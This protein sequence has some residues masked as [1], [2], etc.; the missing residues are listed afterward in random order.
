MELRSGDVKER[1]RLKGLVPDEYGPKPVEID[2]TEASDAAHENWKHVIERYSR[3][4][5]TNAEDKLIALAGIAEM[6]SSPIR[7]RYIVGMWEKYLASQLL[8]YVEPVFED[9]R[10]SYPSRRPKRYRAPSFSWAAVDTPQGIRCAETMREEDLQI[11]VEGIH[12][13]T[14]ADNQFGLVEKGCYVEL[15]CAMRKIEIG[16]LEKKGTINYVWKLWTEQEEGLKQDEGSKQEESSKQEQRTKYSSVYLDSPVDD[17]DDIEGRNGEIYC[18]PAGKD[19]ANYLMCLLLKKQSCGLLSV[20]CYRRVG[21]TTIPPY[22]GGQEMLWDKA[23]KSKM[24]RV[25]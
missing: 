4:A 10:F 18:V 11:S 2:P 20:E 8:W 25:I 14:K 23:G 15:T 6:M 3:T 21:L 9:G 17:F 24:I 13:E 1:V 5:L 12:V 7:G 19:S 16:V 22:V